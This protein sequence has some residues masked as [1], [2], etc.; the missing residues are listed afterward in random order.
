M[1]GENIQDVQHQ[2]ID[3]AVQYLGLFNDVYSISKY[4]VIPW[5]VKSL[6]HFQFHVIKLFSLIRLKFE[7]QISDRRGNMTNSQLISSPYIQLK[8]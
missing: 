6:A 7:A 8:H 2:V 1:N 3:W 4:V 5:V